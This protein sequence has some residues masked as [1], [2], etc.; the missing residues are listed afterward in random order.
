MYPTGR[1]LGQSRAAHRFC[2]AYHAHVKEIETKPRFWEGLFLPFK[3]NLPLQATALL[4]IGAIAIFIFEREPQRELRPPSRQTF[5]VAD[6]TAPASTG[7]A[8]SRPA[9][10]KTKIAEQATAEIVQ[11]PALESDQKPAPSTVVPRRQAEFSRE[12][13]AQLPPEQVLANRKEE[14]KASS[15][16]EPHVPSRTAPPIVATPSTAG[17]AGQ[18]ESAAPTA[19]IAQPP[20]KPRVTTPIPVVTEPTGRA[21]RSGPAPLEMRG[22]ALGST[23]LASE[24][25]RFSAAPDVELIVRRRPRPSSQSRIEQ[26]TSNIDRLLRNISESTTPQT[27]WLTIGQSQYD[28]LK[29]ELLNWGTIESELRNRQRDTDTALDSDNQIGVMLILLPPADPEASQ[30]SGLPMR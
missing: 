21:M 15:A 13:P 26:T 14:A 22:G 20:R 17:A 10:E 24:L 11:N 2:A 5:A 30:P 6:K 8:V 3:I 19:G 18:R 7:P 4:L 9:Q 12:A 1:R 27:A 25:Q 28:Q 23:P 16:P 29:R